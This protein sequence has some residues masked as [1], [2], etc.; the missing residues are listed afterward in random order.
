MSALARILAATDFFALPA[1]PWRASC[2][3]PPKPA[4]AWS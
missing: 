3:W 2:A 4:P 1:M